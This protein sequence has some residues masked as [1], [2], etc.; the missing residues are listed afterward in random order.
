MLTKLRVGA[1]GGRGSDEESSYD[2]GE[3]SGYRIPR[4]KICSIYTGR[5]PDDVYVQ[6]GQGLQGVSADQSIHESTEERKQ[7]YGNRKY[8]GFAHRPVFGMLHGK[9]ESKELVHTESHGD[10]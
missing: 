4:E 9:L 10:Q 8:F 7:V 6:D 2:S 1:T 3:K 5:S